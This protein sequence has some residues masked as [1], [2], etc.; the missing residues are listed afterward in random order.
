[1]LLYVAS[2]HFISNAGRFAVTSLPIQKR[3]A[4]EKCRLGWSV[5]LAVGLVLGAFAQDNPRKGSAPKAAPTPAIS[6]A[7]A[8]ASAL[9][10]SRGSSRG[11]FAT[12][13]L[14]HL[15]SRIRYRGGQR[16]LRRQLAALNRLSQHLDSR[17]CIRR[18][19]DRGREQSLAHPGLSAVGKAVTTEVRQLQPSV[20]S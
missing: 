15:K 1:M 5:A 13:Q 9:Q 2:D 17:S 6:D 4:Y 11:Y 18:D 3:K 20:A 8:G 16:L 7:K 12:P 10:L 14:Q 19:V